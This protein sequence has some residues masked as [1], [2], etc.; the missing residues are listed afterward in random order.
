M[1]I[2]KSYEKP[3]L[4]VSSA[5]LQHIML[6][7]SMVIDPGTGVDD[8]AAKERETGYFDDNQFKNGLW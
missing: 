5:D 1:K 4:I 2:Y 3:E 8:E 6:P 7:D